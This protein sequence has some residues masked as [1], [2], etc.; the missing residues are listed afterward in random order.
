MLWLLAAVAGA[1][2][3]CGGSVGGGKDGAVDDGDASLIDAPIDSPND[4]PIDARV[5][6]APQPID[7]TV[8][9]VG[10]GADLRLVGE[11]IDWDSTNA[12]FIGVGGAAFTV[13]GDI[14]R[15]ATTSP[16][17]GLVLCV[18]SAVTSQVDIVAQNYTRGRLVVDP[19]VFA[20]VGS[21]FEA[22]GLKTGMDAVNQFMEFGQPFNIGFAHILVYKIGAPIPLALSPAINPPQLSFV[23]DGPNDISWSA[24][25]TGTFTLF[26]NRP[27]SGDLTLTSTA[28]FT[29]PTTISLAGGRFT[30]VVIR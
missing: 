3:G 25:D 16:N 18:S 29:G 20:P 26:P 22:R 27:I 2:V 4:P 12:G 8:D 23:S 24:G 14:T 10:C 5:I 7:A 30:I 13:V 15:T 11:L 6:D 19:A 28:T 9:A 17:G 1:A 21:R